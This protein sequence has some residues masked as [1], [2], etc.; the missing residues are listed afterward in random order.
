VEIVCEVMK[1]RESAVKDYLNLHENTWPELIKATRECGFI[2]E[3]VFILKNIVMV[4]MKTENYK[5]S[6]DKLAGTEV[7]KRWTGL[8]RAMLVEDRELFGSRE[9]VTPLKPVWNLSDF[10]A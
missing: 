5:V 7:F 10:P 6:S 3:Y 8:V 4:F 1:L 9:K 2:E